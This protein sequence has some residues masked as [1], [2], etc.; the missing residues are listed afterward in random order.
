MNA[1]V[2][3][4]MSYAEVVFA[5]AAI[6]FTIGIIE[7]GWNLNYEVTKEIVYENIENIKPENYE[8]L[9]SDIELRTGITVNKVTVESI[10]FLKDTAIVI[11]YYNI[12]N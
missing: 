1:F 8:L 7:R 3:K 2:N 9:K 11:M 12:K 5:N 6:V 4:K 10:D